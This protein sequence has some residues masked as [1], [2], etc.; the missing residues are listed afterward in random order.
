MEDPEESTSSAVAS[1]L[2][3]L[4][5]SAQKKVKTKSRSV[6]NAKKAEVIYIDTED[7][8]KNSDIVMDSNGDT[9]KN[10]SIG[11]HPTELGQKKENKGATESSK[12][13]SLSINTKSAVCLNHNGD[14]G[15][16]VLQEPEKGPSPTE[17]RRPCQSTTTV[18]PPMTPQST[19]GSP[20]Y[21]S[22]VNFAIK[23]QQLRQQQYQQEQ[24]R[25][26]RMRQM[27]ML[28]QQQLHLQQQEQQ[29]PKRRAS[30]PPHRSTS[31]TANNTPDLNYINNAF[32]PELM[33]R[34]VLSRVNDRTLIHAC[35]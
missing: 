13:A 10:T 6:G 31:G 21:L 17:Q 27:Q 5:N 35:R 12:Q 15:L 9:R 34:A 7:R 18:P 3:E 16:P 25:F 4:N 2:L 14:G 30:V 1:L 32:P 29:K 20:A 23:Q 28:Q 11:D 22:D 8:D 26:V 33:T 19:T 24:Q